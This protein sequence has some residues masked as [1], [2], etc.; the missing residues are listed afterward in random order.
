MVGKDAGKKKDLK[1]LKKEQGEL[2]DDDRA[3]PRKEEQGESI[4]HTDA[5][6]EMNS[7]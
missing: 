1:P 4:I 2:S 7:H 5:H 6:I 3:L